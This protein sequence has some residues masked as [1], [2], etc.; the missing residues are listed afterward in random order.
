MSILKRHKIKPTPENIATVEKIVRPVPK[1]GMPVSDDTRET[2]QR[3][4]RALDKD[5]WDGLMVLDLLPFRLDK[6]VRGDRYG[7]D[8]PDTIPLP[9][10]EALHA[11]YCEQTG[12]PNASM[13]CQSAPN[14]DP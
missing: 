11:F 2:A 6:D 10:V 13:A 3:L 5:G 9:V 7:V 8:D 4:V 1:R 14:F 12:T